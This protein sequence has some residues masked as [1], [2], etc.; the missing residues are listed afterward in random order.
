MLNKV[1]LIGNIGRDAEIKQTEHG[2]S[3]ANFSIATNEKW[4]DKDGQPQERVEWHK[5]VLWGRAVE[6]IGQYLLKGKQVYVEGSVQ[7]RK[8]KDRE[9][10]DKTTVEVKAHQVRLLGGVGSSSGLEPVEKNG[11]DDY[12]DITVN[13]IPF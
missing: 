4:K 8:W 12:S 6:A 11:R 7:T 1:M 9:G 2:A 13:D 5:I 3:V 10:N